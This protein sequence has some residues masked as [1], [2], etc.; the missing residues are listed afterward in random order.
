M[1]ALDKQVGGN[2]YKRFKI[3]PWEFI[4]KNELSFS[5]G[6]IVKYI[7]RYKYKDGKKDL[8]KIKHY[9]DLL[10]ELHYPDE[11]DNKE[12]D[13]HG[14]TCLNPFLDKQVRVKL[15]NGNLI[16]GTLTEVGYD[17]IS[18]SFNDVEQ[19]LSLNDITELTIVWQE[20]T[21]EKAQV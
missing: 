9:V 18:I 1:S 16:S 2:Y 8:E 10:I 6:C 12:Q 20:T 13:E 3:Q 4:E 5:E 7:C 15:K 14:K 11:V 17:F 19:A 21:D